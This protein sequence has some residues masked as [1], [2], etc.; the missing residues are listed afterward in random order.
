MEPESTT[1]LQ[2]QGETRGSG[3]ADQER[4]RV[5]QGKHEADPHQVLGDGQD[6]RG[7]RKKP[8]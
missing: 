3:T 2:G 6:H 5:G 4:K 8:G 1:T 7:P